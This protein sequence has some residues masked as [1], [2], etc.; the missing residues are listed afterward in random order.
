MIIIHATIQVNPTKEHT[1]MEE[2]QSLI[3]A[4]R[5]ESGNISYDLMKDTE[6]DG[7]YTMVEVWKDFEAV[8]SHN[9]SEHFTYFTG[10][11]SEY[12]TAPLD[13]K[14]F[15]AKAVEKL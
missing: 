6:K 10:K 14:V 4:S 2:V 12:L 8:Q 9:V 7:V 1:F 13:A 3:S 15:E 5:A 11:A